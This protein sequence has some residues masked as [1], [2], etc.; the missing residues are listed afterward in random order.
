MRLLVEDQLPLLVVARRCGVH[1]STIY[2]WKQKWDVLNRHVQMDNPN[3]PGRT[4]SQINHLLRCTWRIPTENSRP[5]TSPAAISQELVDLV[6]AVRAQLK[7]CAE[8]VWHHI[9][10]VLSIS[11]SLSSVRRILWRSSVARGRKKPS[12]PQTIPG[13]H[14]PQSQESLFKQTLFTLLIRRLVD[15]C[16][17]IQSST[18]SLY[19]TCYPCAKTW[20]SRTGCSGSTEVLAT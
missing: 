11:V 18:C 5:H 4:Y 12:A 15:D 2:R 9:T 19:G 1:R 17:T 13:D 6:L 16:I 8:V 20:T 10:K 3:R 14:T 7:R